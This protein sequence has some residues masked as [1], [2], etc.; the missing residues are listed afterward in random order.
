M[1]LLPHLSLIEQY[2]PDDADGALSQP[3]AFVA[4]KVNVCG[5]SLDVGEVMGQGI[6][7]EGWAALMDLR[8]EL[9]PGEKV[10]WYVV[11][12]GDER[13]ERGGNDAGTADEVCSRWL[14]G[15]GG[16]DAERV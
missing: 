12:N 1:N 15:C 7:T 8:D 11:Y 14:F 2:D 4:D 6:A 9:A 16:G 10:G 5:L 3:F 13:R